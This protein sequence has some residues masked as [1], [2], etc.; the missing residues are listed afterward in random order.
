MPDQREEGIELIK[1][2]ISHDAYSKYLAMHQLIYI[3]L[4]FG[5]FDEAEKLAEEIIKVYPQSTFMRWAHSHVFMKKKEL[6][7]AIASYKTLLELIDDDPNA[8]PNHRLTCLGRLAD[9]YS[10]ADSCE[11]ALQIQEK[12]NDSENESLL[13]N[14]EEVQRLILEVSERCEIEKESGE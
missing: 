14:N 6:P 13:E 8:N 12:L 10:R 5:Q 2:T 3:L 11:Q 4:D 7:A 1:K 9:M